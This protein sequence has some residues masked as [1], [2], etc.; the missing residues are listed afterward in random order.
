[1]RATQHIQSEQVDLAFGSSGT[2]ENLADISVM[3]FLK[4]R[5]QRDDLLTR[6][7]LRQVVEML[8]A[9]PLEERRH[10]P[11]INPQR[12]DI[13]ICGAAIIETLMSEFGIAELAI[14][15]RGLRD[16]LLID[17]LAKVETSNPVTGAF[18]A[19]S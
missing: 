19:R 5:R 2:I 17:Y 4:R 1:M 11:G 8:C 14:S 18:G 16:G 7:Q 3:K 13:I 12:A 10:V 9:L 6:E 15:E